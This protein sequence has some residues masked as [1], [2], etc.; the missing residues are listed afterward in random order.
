MSL[1]MN[2]DNYS[3]YDWELIAG[4]GEYD[5]YPIG[6][7]A[8]LLLKSRRFDE[9][10]R[11][12]RIAL[13]RV[14]VSM[15]EVLK[16]WT[17]KEND[18]VKIID[19]L[20]TFSEVMYSVPTLFLRGTVLNEKEAIA[21]FSYVAAGKE[22]GKLTLASVKKYAGNPH[23]RISSK[24]EEFY[25]KNEPYYKL[26]LTL[27]EA[28]ELVRIQLYPDN[29]SEEI[30][31]FGW[32]CRGAEYPGCDLNFP[33]TDLIRFVKSFLDES[34]IEECSSGYFDKYKAYVAFGNPNAF[35]PTLHC[36]VYETVSKEAKHMKIK[37]LT[38][39]PYNIKIEK[40]FTCSTNPL[41]ITLD[42]AR[43]NKWLCNYSKFSFPTFF[44]NNS[45]K[46]AQAKEFLVNAIS[47]LKN[48]NAYLL[49]AQ[50]ELHNQIERA[51]GP[52]Y[53][54]SKK[55]E[56]TPLQSVEDINKYISMNNTP[57]ITKE[58]IETLYN[59]WQFAIKFG[60]KEPKIDLLELQ[61]ILKHI[62][63]IQDISF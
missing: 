13:I 14:D 56:F 62:F 35:S 32:Y 36:I 24:I 12:N 29:L 21:L 16:T 2:I 60:K 37:V 58:G 54:R 39:D 49:H 4:L 6:T 63:P 47:K 5:A 30:S 55:E 22:Y 48:G 9:K 31:L 45:E 59:A 42:L 15:P 1:I 28:E 18:K 40:E 38:I 27:K 44:I 17:L 53:V 57:D 43:I 51:K 3:K 34:P 41:K 23:A 7:C 50:D 61:T 20:N 19:I 46:Q 52:Q 26:P 8:Y 11:S 33:P 10:N 25:D